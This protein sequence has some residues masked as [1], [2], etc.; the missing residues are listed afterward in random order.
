MKEELSPT[1]VKVIIG[2]VVVVALAGGFIFINSGS[3]QQAPTS[4]K[5]GPIHSAAK[6]PPPPPPGGFPHH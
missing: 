3:G 6:G 5:P 2:A 1:L 4:G